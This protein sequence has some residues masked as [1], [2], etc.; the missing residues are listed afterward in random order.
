MQARII[1]KEPSFPKIVLISAVLHLLFISLAV[2]PFKTKEREF[3]SYQVT[4]VG[5]IRQPQAR[6]TPLPRKPLVKEEEK[7]EE[8]KV[9]T[10]QKAVKAPQKTVMTPPKPKADIRLE[11]IEEIKKVAKEI[12]RI[13]AISALSKK[14]EKSREKDQEVQI[15]RDKGVGEVPQDAGVK[16]EGV[17]EDIDF[18]Y[19]IISQKIWQQWVY[20]DIKV[21]GLEVIISIRIGR[22]G[23]VI[24]QEI[25]KSSGDLL[26]DRS[27]IKAI[28][29]ASPL[30]PPPEEME[31]GVRF[32][33]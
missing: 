30:P 31:I 11:K 19:D 9:T 1:G 4:L 17:G 16:G 13:R 32:F 23:K 2:V 15:G 24:L 28:S 29:K 12:E 8:V 27:A 21:S 7:K 10:T 33:L 18:Y 14:L 26:F 22:D 6:R 3:R 20:P 5:P 25:E